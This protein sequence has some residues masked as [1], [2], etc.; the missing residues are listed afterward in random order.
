M[1]KYVTPIVEIFRNHSSGLKV[2]NFGRVWIPGNG[3]GR[4]PN[5]H[6]TYGCVNKLGYLYVHYKGNSYRVHRLVADCFLD[7]PE[8]KPQVDHIDRNQKNNMV[9]NLR[10]ATSSENNYN[11]EVS[12]NNACSKVV[13]QFTKSGE[14]VK[15]WPSTKEVMR[16]LGFNQSHISA[17]C[18]GKLKSAY[19]YIWKY[20]KDED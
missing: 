3:K 1:R 12:K 13:L 14:F 6:F 17:C 19:G 18:N 20:K 5:G 7:N 4:Y 9:E 16:Q 15:E 11:R 2:S 10:W 8:N